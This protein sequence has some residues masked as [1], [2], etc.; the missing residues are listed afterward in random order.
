MK[1]LKAIF[2]WIVCDCAAKMIDLADGRTKCSVC[3]RIV[4]LRLKTR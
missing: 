2:I 3:G 4:K 1:W